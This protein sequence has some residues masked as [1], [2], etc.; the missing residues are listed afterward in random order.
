METKVWLAV[1]SSE[2]KQLLEVTE[3]AARYDEE[4]GS[5]YVGPADAVRFGQALQ[6]WFR[7]V[8]GTRPGEPTLPM[9]VHGMEHPCVRCKKTSLAVVHWEVPGDDITA[10]ARQ[11]LELAASALWSSEAERVNRRRAWAHFG[12]RGSK[13]QGAAYFSNGCRF[14]DVLLGEVPLLQRYEAFKDRPGAVVTLGVVPVP[15]RLV[16]EAFDWFDA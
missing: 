5:W 3:E 13:T 10:T 4:A 14:D 12:V 2:S 9:T 11:P 8:L 7:P 15:A 16:Q 6:T 1:R